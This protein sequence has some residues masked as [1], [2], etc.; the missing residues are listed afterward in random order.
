VKVLI[1]TNILV[2][3]VLRDRLP[4]KIIEAI[5]ARP[6]IQWIVT[7]AILAEY[8]SVLANK[9]YYA[10]VHRIFSGQLPKTYDS[11]PG[12]PANRYLPPSAFP[13]PDTL[14]KS[15]SN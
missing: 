9:T 6:S 3:A 10:M 15:R 8:K 5:I 7:T 2:S 1:D 11:P 13:A 14:F 12:F 4:E